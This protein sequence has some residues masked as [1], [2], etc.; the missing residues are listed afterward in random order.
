[1]RKKCFS[2]I[3]F[4]LLFYCFTSNLYSQSMSLHAAALQGN[5]EAIKQNIEAGVDLDKKDQFG[6]T[7]LIVAITFG[8]TSA[9][10]TLIE[11]GANLNITNNEESTPLH[12]S[13]FFGNEELAKLLIEN[14]ADKY[15]RNVNGSSPFDIAA[16]PLE[17]DKVFLDKLSAALSPLGFN[18]D[19]DQIKKS[20]PKIAEIIRPDKDE[21]AS[22]DY[23]PIFRDDWK[24]ST[25][26]EEGID[27][28]LIAE[29]YNDAAH[30]ETLYSLL[31]IK[32]GKL[33]AEGY[34]NKASIDQL[35][36]RAS[37]TKSFL[38]A[39]IGIAIEKECIPGLDEKM[40]N[41]FPE[42]VNEIKDERKKS[43]TIR[44]MLQMRSGYPWEETDSS[45]WNAIWSGVYPDKIISI[46]LT[47]APGEKFQYSNLTSNW[48]SII[49]SRACDEDLK[50]FGQKNLFE[51]LG[52]EL[53]DWPQD[54]DGYRIG[55]GDIQFTSRDLAKFGLLYL[56]EGNYEGT[57]IVPADWVNKSF[58]TYSTNINTAGIKFGRVGRYF[59]NIGY[60]LHWWSAEAGDHKLNLAWGHG[61]QFILLL[62]DLDM[63]IVTTADPFWGKE[64]HFNAWK[65][66]QA[67]TNLLGKFLSL[68]PS[69]M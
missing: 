29:F 46:P 66:E 32:N 31:V 11:A 6:S 30:L 45:Y 38:S 47:A 9:A 50:I 34:F 4:T 67:V 58:Q 33:I 37:I 44:Q 64:E 43:I 60:D 53:G 25:P 10:K 69:K 12:L 42:I 61:G 39:L 2:V 18:A 57:Q 17:Y 40:I 55:S 62:E 19:Y 1:M 26:E 48:L 23:K 51:P 56:N 36:K 16:S 21:Q 22:I 49:T 24:N 14:G 3:I 8:K 15:I 63:I 27:P 7:P 68:L 52:I 20:R 35:S 5:L 41:Y 54:V 28:M 59:H 13:A 65:H